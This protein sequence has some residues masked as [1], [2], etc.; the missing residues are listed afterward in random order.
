MNE[1]IQ[2]LEKA[3]YELKTKLSEARAGAVPQPVEDYAL[4]GAAG[5]IRLSELF[6]DKSNLLTVHNMGRGCP[7]CTLWADGLNGLLK[8]IEERTAFVV[9]SPNT[10]E[11]QAEFA[12]S[13]GWKFRMASDASGDFTRAMGFLPDG[14]Y[15]PGVSAFH[16]SDDGSITRTNFT[17]FGPGDDFCSVWPLFE[18][19]PVGAKGWEPSL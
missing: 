11:I 18:L 13:R 19:L 9:V 4:V 3:I 10:P 15:W 7:Y 5:E 17:F 1:E 8:H 14:K 16:K 12:V 6:G 2:Q